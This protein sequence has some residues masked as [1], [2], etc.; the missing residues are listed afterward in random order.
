MNP[1]FL[2]KGAAAAVTVL[3]AAG[4]PAAAQDFPTKPIQM[5]VPFGQGG[6]TDQLARMFA[7]ALEER[8]GQPI[9]IINQ[10]GAGGA[11]GLANL[12]TM[13]ADGYTV[14][15]GSDSTLA[16][17]P[18]MDSSS[19]TADSFDTVARMV[20]IPSGLAVRADSPY[21]SLTDLV[22][23]MRNGEDLNWSG[24]GIGSGPHL[25]MAVF[26][27]Q[28]DLEATYINSNSGQEAM[29][30]LLSGEIDV[31][32]GGGSNY[33]PMLDDQGQG[34]I[35]VLGLA[36]EERWK[37]MPDVPTFQEQGL[38]YLRSQWFGLV[39]PQGTPQEA[40]D[41]ISTAVEETLADPEFEARLDQ[42]YFDPAY[43]GPEEMRAAIDAE[44]EAFR[45]ILEEA[46]LAE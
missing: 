19:Y 42:F 8:L 24:S 22:E 23:A 20:S 38:D 2:L 32:S 29:V 30:K 26:L 13:A 7:P 41:K 11:V 16:A 39:A 3:L 10:P 43:L 21:Q 4:V 37:Y 18:I 28:N 35:R 17:R 45:P 44:A 36:A 40:I 27:A 34:D 25:A 6:A 31:F 33:P 14:G 1:K 5:I 15:V 46:G 12:A 9:V